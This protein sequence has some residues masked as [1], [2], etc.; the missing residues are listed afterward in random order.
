M[1]NLVLNL[2]FVLC[3]VVSFAQNLPNYWVPTSGTDTYTASITS[4]GSS[5]SNK[6]A[7]VKFGNTNTGA[8]TININSIGAIALRY[9]DGNSWE[10]L[11]VSHIDVNTV[12]K[13]AYSGSFFELESFGSGGGG[14]SVAWGDITGTLPDQ[15]DLQSALDSKQSLDSDLTAIAG[16]SPSND[17]IIQ[18][19]SGVWINR[20]LAQYKADLG[21]NNVENTALSTWAGSTNITTLGTIS[22]GTVPGTLVSNTPAGGIAATNSQAAINEIDTEKAPLASPAL[23]GTPTAPTASAGT[24]NTQIATTAY[25]DVSRFSDKWK[26]S[27]RASSTANG[28]LSTAY[29]NGDAIDGITLATGDRILI[30]FQTTSSENGI[31]TVNASGAPTRST[32]ADAAAELE[33]AVVLVQE[34]SLY[35]NQIF[36]QVTD[37]ITLGTSSIIFIRNQPFVTPEQFGAVGNGSTDDEPAI[38]LAVNSGFAVYFDGKKDYRVASTVELPANTVI[39]G[40]GATVSCNSLIA[41][42]DPDND[43]FIDGLNFNGNDVGSS[44]INISAYRNKLSNCHFTGFDAAGLFIQSTNGVS[45]NP[46]GI[47][48]VNCYFES[49]DGRGVRCFTSGEY[50][51]FANCVAKGNTI[52][53]VTFGAGNNTWTGGKI[54]DNGIGLEITSGSNNGH[55]TVTGVSINHNTTNLSIV[56]VSNGFEI[57]TNDIIDGHITITTSNGINLRGNRI[58]GTVTLTQTNNTNTN[59][60]YNHF[61]ANPTFVTTGTGQRYFGNTFENA[62]PSAVTNSLVGKLDITA[63]TVDAFTAGG[64]LA[65]TTASLQENVLFNHVTTTRATTSDIFR[66]VN[67]APTITAGAASQTLYAVNIDGAGMSNTNSPTKYML[68]VE[69]GVR[70]SMGSSTTASTPLLVNRATSNGI[71]FNVQS[72]GN[73]LFTV[74]DAAGSSSATITGRLTLS[75]GLNFAGTFIPTG[76]LAHCMN[77]GSTLESA[78]DNDVLRTITSAPV[79]GANTRTG[80]TTV[81][82]YHNPTYTV[83]SGSFTN[84]SGIIIDNTASS[85]VHT[86]GFGVAAPTAQLHIGAS[87]TAANTASIKIA[88]GSRQTSAED[89]TIN[90]VSNNLE[91]TE[92]ST[93]YIIAK[94]LTAT[95]SLDFPSVSAGGTQTLTITVTGASDGDIALVSIPNAAKSAGLIFGTAWVSAADTVSIEVYNSTGSPIDPA[96]A[97]FRASVIKY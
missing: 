59:W 17:D 97:T 54:T 86:N 39:I 49:C 79:Y 72:N 3:S 84:R 6:I 81:G 66:S 15:T 24:N 44:G 26:S 60:T 1:K 74:S 90:Y 36:I 80:V 55:G 23:T 28:T 91:F 95:A 18:R 43:C 11:P 42:F 37:N 2:F 51:N 63:A 16:L 89:G 29:E 8:S 20:T 83:S 68:N 19:K 27:V 34:G 32:D 57:C 52:A 75:T 22:T 88:E 94:T 45:D 64:I 10:P 93:P 65:A 13:I 78:A 96:S 48:V 9:W 40:N 76:G 21:L 56:S 41:I 71:I 53:G 50:N 33:G 61:V 62:I 47:Q 25:V 70:I 46:G 38:Q 5:Y 35:R 12:Y 92:T 87:T 69:G 31:Y 30:Q 85:V 4:F 67:F 7:F 77:V 14:G 58:D 82:F 73:N